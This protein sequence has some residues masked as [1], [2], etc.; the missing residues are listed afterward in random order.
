MKILSVLLS[1]SI[2]FTAIVGDHIVFNSKYSNSF[3]FRALI[4][5][6]VH[7]S[8]GT[9]S[10]LLFFLKMDITRQACVYNV[11]LCTIVSSLID[12]DH[13]IVAKS[14]YF[15]VNKPIFQIRLICV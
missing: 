9:V 3:L 6:F 8:I 2:G 7:A 13:F 1:L 14:V 4:D 5:N 10:A 15:K 11:L 12:L